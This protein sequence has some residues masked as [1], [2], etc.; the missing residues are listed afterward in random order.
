MRKQ[1]NKKASK[2]RQSRVNPP[3]ETQDSETMV[4]NCEASKLTCPV[5]IGHQRYRALIDTGSM[6]CVARKEV[7]DRLPR[8]YKNLEPTGLTIRDAS[9]GKLDVLGIAKCDIRIE[10]IKLSC[11]FHVVSQLQTSMII[12]M[13]F[14][15]QHGARIDLLNET[16]DIIKHI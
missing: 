7:Y 2:G 8:R 6:I 10:G 14:L 9:G 15:K 5:S 16:L 11:S 4:L 12:G 13:D 1:N 3:R